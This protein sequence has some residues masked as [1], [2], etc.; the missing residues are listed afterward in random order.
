M[1][2]SAREIWQI[3]IFYCKKTMQRKP[4]RYAIR[5][6]R[7][8]LSFMIKF[9]HGPIFNILFRLWLVVCMLFIK[10]LIDKHDTHIY[11]SEIQFQC[12]F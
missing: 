11:V 12:S 8:C 5:Y 6:M 9:I 4:L 10:H 2:T 7:K 1:T 3:W